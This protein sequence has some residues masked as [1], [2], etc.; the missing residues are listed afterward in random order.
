VVHPV[1]GVEES[2]RFAAVVHARFGK[3]S[4]VATSAEAS[5]FSMIENDG[6]DGVVNF[7]RGKCFDNAKAHVGCQR[8][9]RLWPI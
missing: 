6:F 8:M 4:D 3:H 5:A 7:E 9:K 2:M 1:F